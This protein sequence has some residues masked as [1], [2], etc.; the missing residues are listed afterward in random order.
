MRVKGVAALLLLVADAALAV[1]PDECEQQRAAYPRVWN[2]VSGD[3]AVFSCSSHYSGYIKIMLGS[4]DK[5]GRR[6]MSIVP[7]SGGKDS[8]QDRSKNVFRIW[9]D[10]EQ[11][12][13]LGDG[14]YFATIVRQQSSC[15][16]RGALSTEDGEADAVLLMDNANPGPDGLRGD[17]GPFYNKAP[18]FSVFQG[19]AYYC[20][21]IE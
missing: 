8:E 16:I 14:R 4:G 3:K 12:V 1:A 15:W 5:D 7:L 10:R 18:R 21:R 6:L 11:A 9:L 2:D 13:R 17:A 19:N 20:E